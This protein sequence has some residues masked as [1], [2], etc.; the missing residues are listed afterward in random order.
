MEASEKFI[1]EVFDK[2]DELDAMRSIPTTLREIVEGYVDPNILKEAATPNGPFEWD[3]TPCLKH[4]PCKDAV[5]TRPELVAWYAIQAHHQPGILGDCEVQLLLGSY[6]TEMD[7]LKQY[8]HLK[9]NY[10]DHLKAERQQMLDLI[11]YGWFRRY[12]D[13]DDVV[14]DDDTCFIHHKSLRRAYA[15]P[16]PRRKDLTVVEW[17]ELSSKC[18]ATRSYWLECELRKRRALGK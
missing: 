15:L 9:G 16:S 2:I 13:A 5:P 17:S 6:H 12:I 14:L 3:Y 7:A 1:Q 4:V 11:P 18:T 10:I 8:P